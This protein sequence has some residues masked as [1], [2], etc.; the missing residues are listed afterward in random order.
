LLLSSYGIKQ[1]QDWPVVLKGKEFRM[2][3]RRRCIWIK[4]KLTALSVLIVCAVLGITV[5]SCRHNPDI[6]SSPQVSFSKDVQPV[7][8]SNCTM[9]GCH[10]G[11]GRLHALLTYDQI[12][13]A[14]LV[15]PYSPHS[16]NLYQRITGSGGENKMPPAGYMSEQNIETIYVWILQGAKNN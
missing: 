3:E 4:R 16:S 15:T 2:T 5:I 7:I 12:A 11:D 14:E 1:W 10:S 6:S 9:S 8:V 13:S